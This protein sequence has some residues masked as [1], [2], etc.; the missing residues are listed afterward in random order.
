M[1]LKV[2]ALLLS[3][4]SCFVNAEPTGSDLLAECTMALNVI[5]NEDVPDFGITSATNSGICFGRLSAFR[6]M[7]WM[8]SV[9]LTPEQLLYC[10]PYT[11]QVP[12]LIRVVVK[13]L[14]DNPDKLHIYSNQLVFQALYKAFP[15]D[16]DNQKS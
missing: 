7:N 9:S 14:K 3:L 15:C 12:Q 6:D 5:D 2:F 16:A 10:V 1:K 11:A 8:Y 4:C 13:Y